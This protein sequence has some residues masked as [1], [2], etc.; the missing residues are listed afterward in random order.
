[1]KRSCAGSSRYAGGR[2]TAFASDTA[3]AVPAF[4][5][6]DRLQDRA[7]R[8]ARVLGI[9]DERRGG[10]PEHAQLLLAPARRGVH[11]DREEPAHAALGDVR[12]ELHLQVALLAV[13]QGAH[14]LVGGAV[15]AHHLGEIGGDF[16]EDRLAHDL[17]QVAADDLFGSEAEEFG[18]APVG[19]HA[20]QPLVVGHRHRRD[21]VGDEAKLRR[22]LPVR[23]R[24]DDGIGHGRWPHR[25]CFP[26]HAAS[27]PEALPREYHWHIR[28]P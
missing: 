5:L 20:A 14:P 1:M 23:G 13:G 4:G 26:P 7:D 18:V 11:G 8:G 19:E 17:A 28:I 6:A 3:A 22:V 25:L 24:Q 2:T 15:A 16:L 9:G 27:V 21:A 12:D 10:E